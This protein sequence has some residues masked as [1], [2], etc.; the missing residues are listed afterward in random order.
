MSDR[1]APDHRVADRLAVGG[2]VLDLQAGELLTGDGQLAGQVVSKDELMR[3]VWPG[4]VV[5]EGS[6]TQAIA[7]IR[8]VLG[9]AEHRLVRNVARRGYLLVTA[10][11]DEALA[12][13]ATPAEA[14]APAAPGE[15][16]GPA[17][18]TP[19]SQRLDG[20]T[21]ASSV[22]LAVARPAAHPGARPYDVAAARARPTA[23]LRPGRWLLPV[24]LVVLVVAGGAGAVWQ[25][26][27]N[28]PPVWQTPADLARVPLPREVPALS[29]VVLPL[30]IE[31][32]AKDHEWL[33]DALHGDLVIEV[34]RLPGSLVIA[35]DTAA[36][37]K[38]KVVD[39][40]QVARE[41]GVGMSC[42]APCASRARRSGSAWR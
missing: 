7:D 41:M 5:G 20:A 19:N 34:A 26:G 6:L 22:T 21:A 13:P 27:R 3:R 2:F 31:G 12:A 24:V 16:P 11:V 38:G 35:R 33:A 30:T 10:P 39:P 32:D 17:T 1:I 14:R 29:I 8:R 18:D 25:A 28:A 15:A 40:R 37:Y 23:R 42:R 36:T 4:V 9:D